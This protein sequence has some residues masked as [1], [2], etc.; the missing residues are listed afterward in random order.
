MNHCIFTGRLTKDPVLT[1]TKGEKQVS[2]VN[3]SLAVP[4]EF[5]KEGDSE[6]DFINIVA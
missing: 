5:V 2:V 3:F 4:R 6:A 1:K